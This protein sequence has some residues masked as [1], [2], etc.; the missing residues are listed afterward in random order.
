MCCCLV[1]HSSRHSLAERSAATSSS[2]SRSSRSSSRSPPPPPPPPPSAGGTLP[3]PAPRRPR[4][5]PASP[6]VS[7]A[8]LPALRLPPR[9][10][11]L[12]GSSPI[13]AASLRAPR[14][15][16]C[17]PPAPCRAAL[18]RRR[19]RR[20]RRGHP[21]AARGVPGF[22]PA[23]APRPAP[24]LPRRPAAPRR[25]ELSASPGSAPG[26]RWTRGEDRSP[27]ARPEWGG[28]KE[29]EEEGT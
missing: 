6:Q 13:P 7:S 2:S 11:R 1:N 18:R 29:K 25:L 4:P 10:S 12:P 28:S 5:S 15:R 27:A 23:A 14:P 21:P 20:R 16:G 9:A 3:P 22:S 26:R 8:F 24:R 17:Q 19:R